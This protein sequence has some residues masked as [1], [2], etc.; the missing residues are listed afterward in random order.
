MAKN[1]E[2][3]LQ[4]LNLYQKASDGYNALPDETRVIAGRVLT[5]TRISQLEHEKHRLNR[6]HQ[7][8]LAEINDHLKNLRRSLLEEFKV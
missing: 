5:T 7:K 6:M 4:A 1:I 3:I 8:H 2:N